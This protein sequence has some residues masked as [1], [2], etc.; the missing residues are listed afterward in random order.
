MFHSYHYEPCY[1]YLQAYSSVEDWI[2]SF[3]RCPAAAFQ[4]L[5]ALHSEQDSVDVME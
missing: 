4:N 5:Y 1:V 2:I 3:Q